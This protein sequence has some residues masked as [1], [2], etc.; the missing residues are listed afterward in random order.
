MERA[1]AG[2]YTE[3]KHGKIEREVRVASELGRGTSRLDPDQGPTSGR[4][5]PSPG[6]TGLSETKSRCAPTK[7]SH[8]HLPR[9]LPPL[10]RL[11]CFPRPRP[12]PRRP[13]SVRPRAGHVPTP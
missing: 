8:A 4:T 11:K 5:S 7:T 3:I 12:A 13:P 6:W 9:T 10:S 1:R 2:C